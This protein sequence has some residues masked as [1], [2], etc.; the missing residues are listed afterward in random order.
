MNITI[1]CSQSPEKAPPA[2]KTSA[3][4]GAQSEFDDLEFHDDDDFEKTLAALDDRQIAKK[5]T[6]AVLDLG[7]YELF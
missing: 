4:G 2:A 5:V 1:L 3:T 7:P 6:F